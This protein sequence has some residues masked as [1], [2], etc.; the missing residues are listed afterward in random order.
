MIE[1]P[2]VHVFWPS[3][4]RALNDLSIFVAS[5]LLIAAM[6]CLPIGRWSTTDASD[7]RRFY[8]PVA[9]NI[10]EGRGLVTSRG[11]AAIEYPPGFPAVL[12]ILFGLAR[13]SGTSEAFWLQGFTLTA[14]G[15][16]A[17]LFYRLAESIVGGR[18]AVVAVGLWLTCPFLLW[19]AKQP[20]SEIA[21]LPI[22]N[23]MLLVYVMLVQRSGAWRALVC[24]VL[25]GLATSVRPIALLLPLVLIGGLLTAFPS[26]WRRWAACG[27][28]IVAGC[29]VV[30]LPW[31]LWVRA[32]TGTWIPASTSGPRS[33]VD[34]LTFAIERR[35]FRAPVDTPVRVLPVMSYIA[36]RNRAGE[37]QTI[38]QILD[39][40]ANQLQ[41]RPMAVVQLF[42]W[43]GVRAW[44]ATDAGRSGEI[45]AL[46]IQSGYFCLTI[47]G[48]CILWR[49]STQS[50]QLVLLTLC[51]VA[52][53][54]AA[55]ISVL[56]IVRYMIP[57]FGL[58]FPFTAVAVCK[59]AGVICK[60]SR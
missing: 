12:A 38:R 39:A 30:L 17:V 3:S 11:A 60:G 50:R 47:A 37:V 10:L 43:K 34:G 6:W 54:W 2:N 18:R 4:N 27:A 31:E 36:D 53:F 21:F 1:R 41:E 26:M 9:R 22:F 59:L 5:T 20:H 35:D 33:V 42:L 13:C 14:L 32:R 57:V 15:V 46:G 25:A 8:A 40:L 56:S 51:V 16:A 48:M 52:Y 55:T 7:Y 58:L 49:E 19:T 24:G 23:A 28:L 45:Y 44:Y 29:A